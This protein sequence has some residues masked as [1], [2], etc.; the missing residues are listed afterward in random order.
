MERNKTNECHMCKHKRSIPGDVHIQ[1]INPDMSMTGNA[2]G[3]KNGWFMYPINFDPCW[4]TKDCAN[5]ET[6]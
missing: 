2:H 3:I 5:F 4:K 1:C 6:A